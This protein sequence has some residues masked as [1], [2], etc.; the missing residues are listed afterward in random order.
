[1]RVSGRTI[2][3]LGS[4]L[5]EPYPPENRE[6]F[7][8]IVA[9]H[10]AVISELPMTAP[11]MAEN[12]PRR[13]RIISGSALGATVVEEPNRCGA[14]MTARLAAEEHHREVMAVPGRI[15]SPASAGCHRIIREGWATLVG[16]TGDIL[17][18][19]GETGQLLRGAMEQQHPH[20]ETADADDRST[21]FDDSPGSTPP[22]PG[23]TG[24]T[25]TQQ[26]LFDAITDDPI[27]LD[28]IVRASGLAIAT[29]QSELTMLELR[30]LVERLPAN[31]VKRRSKSSD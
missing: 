29:V 13:N 30:R 4:G 21:L 9:D 18:A 14:D 3:V 23:A 7:D 19:L 22:Q 27:D 15:D 11:P 25:R 17:D 2:V 20:A 10:G 8:Q 24:L 16:S 5:A 26:R 28:Q 12:F 6:L 31:R 1:M